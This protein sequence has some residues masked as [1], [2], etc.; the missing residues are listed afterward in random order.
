MADARDDLYRQVATATVETDDRT[1]EAVAA[2]VVGL[3]T[4]VATQPAPWTP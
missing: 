3:V 1:P 2:V 4:G